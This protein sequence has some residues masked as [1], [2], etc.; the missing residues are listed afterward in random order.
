[1]LDSGVA[2]AA[3]TW[4]HVVG[5]WDGS[6]KRIY[7]NGVL[8]ASVAQS[9]TITYAPTGLFQLGANSADTEQFTGV[10]D[11]ARVSNIAR[12]TDWIAA[13]YN[14]QSSPGTFYTAAW[15]LTS[16]GSPA[17]I[18]AVSPT[19]LTFSATSGGANPAAQS[20]GISSSN[21]TALGSWT[22]SANNSWITLSTTPTGTGQPSLT[23]TGA[24]AIYVQVAT[25]SLGVG[26]TNGSL[27]I[28]AP[29]ATST[30]Q[31]VSVAA[32]ISSGTS[33]STWPNGYSYAATLTI[34]H[35][36]VPN[37]DQ[38]N[39]PVLVSGTYADLATTVNGGKVT[40]PNGYDIIF[41]SDAN[42]LNVLNFERESYSPATGQVAYWVQAPL[43]SHTTD[44]V[45]YVFYGNAAVST[46]PSKPLGA[47]D[48]NYQ[49]V[50]HFANGTVLTAKDSTTHGINGQ[51]T[52]ATATGGEVGGGANLNG[53][54]WVNMG[55]N[56]ASLHP[57]NGLTV[58]SWVKPTSA[59]Q[60]N[61][62]GMVLQDYSNPR[63][64]PWVSYKLGLNYLNHGTYEF[65][66][67]TNSA[68]DTMLDSGVAFAAGT[69]AHV[70]GTWDGSTKRI[71]VNG[72]LKGSAAQTGTISYS[73]T[74]LFAF[75]ANSSATEQATLVV[76]EG[77]VSNI[78]RSADWIA[79]EY[80]NQSS[81]ATFYAAVWGQTYSG[82]TSG[83]TP[84]L[85][86][87]Q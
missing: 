6:T 35:G 14:N 28:S 34:A 70:V 61:Y 24:A 15:G 8:K 20:V 26:T 77:R 17:P 84:V 16:G 32:V 1:M 55:A 48:G 83:T 67:S 82:G 18:L 53:N 27:S 10:V 46:D 65:E 33:G 85:T 49:G 42:G 74:G 57:A 47:W 5:T 3:G 52:S 19:M 2:F 30:P 80:N 23:G 39:F 13:E 21:S 68:T 31:G 64:S 12:S 73:P 75:G 25:G 11:E 44:T 4:A 78:A 63:G 22:A 37:T 60:N 81:P 69:W 71:Y 79:A 36:K 40:N 29:G 72:V 58:E 87:S 50:W 56:R 86:V 51:I 7:V 9:G 41:T 66:L 43:L 62:A 59:T 54:A 45:I 38:S 76:D